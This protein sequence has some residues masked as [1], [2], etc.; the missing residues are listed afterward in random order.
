MHNNFFFFFQIKTYL[1]LAAI[2]T[3]GVGKGE[4]GYVKMFDLIFALLHIIHQLC[5]I[6]TG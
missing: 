2:K 5:N 1:L 3:K 4:K 6:S